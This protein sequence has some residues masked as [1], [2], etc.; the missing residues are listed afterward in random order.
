MNL[1]I[2]DKSNKK[3]PLNIKNRN[4]DLKNIPRMSFGII[5][6]IGLMI[7][8]GFN[9]SILILL[10]IFILLLSYSIYRLK[11]KD[12]V[13]EEEMKEY[14]NN[15]PTRKMIK[16]LTL[17]ITE[18]KELKEKIKSQNENFLNDLDDV[19]EICDNFNDEV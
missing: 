6:C 5:C 18:K 7:F 4:Q 8:T 13:T 17:N 3:I 16:K 14:R 19:I 1:N 11:T 2:F 10:L 15:N 9:S 12:I